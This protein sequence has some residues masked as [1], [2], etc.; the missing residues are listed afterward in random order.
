MNLKYIYLRNGGKIQ[1]IVLCALSS[2]RFALAFGAIISFPKQQREKK[3]ATKQ[4][5]VRSPSTTVL[6]SSKH[7]Y[8]VCVAHVFHTSSHRKSD[9][10]DDDDDDD[11]CWVSEKFRHRH[12]HT[13]SAMHAICTI[14]CFV[15][16]FFAPYLLTSS[17]HEREY[18]RA[19]DFRWNWS[20]KRKQFFFCFI[21]IENNDRAVNQSSF[22]GALSFP[23]G[24]TFHG[25]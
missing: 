6:P 10:E 15:R 12:T 13:H 22:N 2:N 5:F 17:K 3:W 25:K 20:C 23:F 9:S 24:F 7:R 11:G 18:E 16:Q 4:R 14:Y 1:T 21:I 19:I 8:L